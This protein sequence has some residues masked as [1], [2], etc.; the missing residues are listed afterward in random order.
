MTTP[1]DLDPAALTLEMEAAWE[2]L[3]VCTKQY[4][5]ERIVTRMQRRQ[6]ALDGPLL[7]AFNQICQLLAEWERRTHTRPAEHVLQSI[8]SE[9][10]K[11]QRRAEEIRA[12]QEAAK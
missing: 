9:V 10:S 8:Q 6:R 3:A 5:G 1:A 7:S 11:A 4:N 2:A 12:I